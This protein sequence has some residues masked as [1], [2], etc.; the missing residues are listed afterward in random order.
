MKVAEL[1][2]RADKIQGS[3]GK[4]KKYQCESDRKADLLFDYIAKCKRQEND[5]R[6]R[7][8]NELVSIQRALMQKKAIELD[9]KRVQRLEDA[10]QEKRRSFKEVFCIN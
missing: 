10:A 9:E 5:K 4:S 2:R 8:L 3:H 7:A 1:A 6:K